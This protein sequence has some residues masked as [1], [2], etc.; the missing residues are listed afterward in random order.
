MRSGLT[1]RLAQPLTSEIVFLQPASLGKPA[2][3]REPGRFALKTVESTSQ[4]LSTAAELDWEAS[5]NARMYRVTVSDTPDFQAALAQ[6]MVGFPPVVLTRLPPP[7]T[8]Y[9][10]A[11]SRGMLPKKGHELVVDLAVFA[12]KTLRDRHTRRISCRERR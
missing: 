3:L 12:L 4:L 9:W 6:K 11:E 7:R 5:Q 1:L 2:D 10:K 8:A